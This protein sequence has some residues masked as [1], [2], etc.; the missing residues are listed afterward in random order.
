MTGHTGTEKA[1][2]CVLCCSSFVN[3][4]HVSI[5]LIDVLSGFLARLHGYIL[6]VLHSHV[7]FVCGVCLCHAR[8]C[9]AA[10]ESKQ[11]CGPA[12]FPSDSS[13]LTVVTVV[14]S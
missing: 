8:V 14:L 6:A 4:Q 5:T 10:A 7:F 1:Y 2:F 11:L 3:Y 12:V 13:Q 9:V